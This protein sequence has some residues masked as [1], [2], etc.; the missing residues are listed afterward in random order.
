MN[1][2]DES[3]R[4]Y[5]KYVDFPL[6]LNHLLPIINEVIK[7]NIYF[8]NQRSLPFDATCFDASQGQSRT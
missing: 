1:S 2:S 3:T 7:E 5:S 8:I 6:K 4:P